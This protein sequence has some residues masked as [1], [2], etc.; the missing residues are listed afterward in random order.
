MQQDFCTRLNNLIQESG[1]SKYQ[2][3]KDLQCGKATI[4]NWCTGKNEPKVAQ[5]CQLCQYFDVSADYLLGLTEYDG[6]RSR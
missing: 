4:L 6:M 5:I 1:I 2:L 3:A